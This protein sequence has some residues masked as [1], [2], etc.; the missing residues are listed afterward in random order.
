MRS[1]KSVLSDPKTLEIGDRLFDALPDLDPTD[2][3]KAADIQ[4]EIGAAL[5][6]LVD[7]APPLVKAAFSSAALV[8]ALTPLAPLA[9]PEESASPKDPSQTRH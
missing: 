3:Q 5:A 6:L 1:I 7:T 4:E 2:T 9:N 8:L